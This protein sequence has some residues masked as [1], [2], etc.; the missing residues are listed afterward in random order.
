MTWEELTIFAFNIKLN[1][2][3]DPETEAP[4]V[5]KIQYSTL[6]GYVLHICMSCI[7][8]S[9]LKQLLTADESDFDLIIEN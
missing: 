5:S 1:A 4:L 7:S 9:V 6:V 8:S 3:G 2:P